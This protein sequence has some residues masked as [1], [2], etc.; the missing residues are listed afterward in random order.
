MRGPR[1]IWIVVTLALIV[2]TQGSVV[3]VRARNEPRIV[4]EL[5]HEVEELPATLGEWQLLQDGMIDTSIEE[6]VMAR[7]RSDDAMTRGYVHPSGRTCSVHIAV[8]RDP[9]EWTPHPPELCYKGAGFVQGQKS[10][11]DLPGR[12][13]QRV[14]LTEFAASNT[15]QQVS[16]IYWYQIGDKAYVDRDSGRAIRRGLWGS[17]ERPPMVKVLLQSG[18]LASDDEENKGDLL[19]LAAQIHRFASGL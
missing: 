17:P 2:A 15:G 7:L 9:E 6:G 11:V 1:V 8:W 10:Q 4:R 14:R 13:K 18:E 3:A 19:E 16:V 12:D 5:K